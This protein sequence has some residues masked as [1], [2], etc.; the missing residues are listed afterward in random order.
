MF[1]AGHFRERYQGSEE[2]CVSEGGRG[3]PIR[4]ALTDRRRLGELQP[5]EAVEE[6][7]GRGGGDPG[8]RQTGPTLTPVCISVPAEFGASQAPCR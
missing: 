6:G 5:A 2:I 8:S 1:Y 3:G 4:S 7:G